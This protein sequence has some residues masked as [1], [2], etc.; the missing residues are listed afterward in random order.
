MMEDE[1]MESAQNDKENDASD[2]H[3]KSQASD[4]EDDEAEIRVGMGNRS[5]NKEL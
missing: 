4:E 2:E 5:P 1:D 3:M